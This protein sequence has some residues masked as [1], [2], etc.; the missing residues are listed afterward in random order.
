MKPY[1]LKLFCIRK[2]SIRQRVKKSNHYGYFLG[3]QR[4]R[5]RERERE[6]E[7]GKSLDERLL[8]IREKRTQL[9]SL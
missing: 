5:E 4:K 9:I 3:Q 6:I 2:L 7:R 1:I 8:K